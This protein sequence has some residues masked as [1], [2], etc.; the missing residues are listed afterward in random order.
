MRLFTSFENAAL[1]EN[2]LF[3]TLA[4][5]DGLNLETSRINMVYYLQFIDDDIKSC[6]KLPLHMENRFSEEVIKL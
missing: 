6:K 2:R 4:V 5:L 3:H 1:L